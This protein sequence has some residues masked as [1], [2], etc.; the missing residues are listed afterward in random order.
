MDDHETAAVLQIAHEVGLGGLAQAGPFPVAIVQ[1]E[2][3]VIENVVAAR[4]WGPTAGP[5]G[6]GERG[7]AWRR[8]GPLLGGVR[9]GLKRSH[10]LDVLGDM[11]DGARILFQCQDERR[12]CGPPV[13]GRM[14]VTGQD[15]R[16][17]SLERL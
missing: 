2:Q 14:V 3:V 8:A 13:V 10:I 17:E 15:E 7:S 11:D 1:N 4:A 12:G 16:L 9:G 6:G 5:S